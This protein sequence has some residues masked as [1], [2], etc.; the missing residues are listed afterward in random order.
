MGNV[1]YVGKAGLTCTL[2]VGTSVAPLSP[3]RAR[4]QT[5]EFSIVEVLGASRGKSPLII[6]DLDA[7]LQLPR[8]AG[9]PTLSSEEP[10][11]PASAVYRS[12]FPP[13]PRPFRLSCVARR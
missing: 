4:K 6:G 2:C 8:T 3:A 10:L 1:G 9:A 12:F 5:V 7:Y 11:F 13:F